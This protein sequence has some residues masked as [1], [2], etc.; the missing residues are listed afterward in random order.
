MMVPGL[1][2]TGP[3]G[4]GLVGSSSSSGSGL[5]KDSMRWKGCI[6]LNYYS[7]GASQ[8]YML[9]ARLPAFHVRRFLSLSTSKPKIVSCRRMTAAPVSALN[10]V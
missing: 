5:L 3:D 1:T 6:V 2:G 9:A 8:P 4:A 10:M 7:V